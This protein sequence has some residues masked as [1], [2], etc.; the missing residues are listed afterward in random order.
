MYLDLL[1]ITN[2][3]VHYFLLLLTARLFYRQASAGR[4]LAGAALGASAVLLLP[5]SPPAGVAFA[6]ILAAPLLMVLAAFWPLGWADLL[7]CWGALFL[8][9]FMLA[10]AVS[11]LLNFESARR[12]FA[13][14]GGILL[15]LG[16][17]AALSRLLVL[18]RPFSEDKKWQKR[19]QV[20]LEVA[21]QGK[22]KMVPAFLDTGNRLRDP[23]CS[24]PVIV[25]DYRSLEGMLPPPVYRVLADERLEPW[26]ALGKLPDPALARHFTLIPCRGVGAENQLL[27]GL[28]PD[29]IILHEGGE[30]RSMESGLFLGLSRQGFG[31][32]AE[33]R[34]LLPPELLRAG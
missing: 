32:A 14:P 5:F 8:F 17:S 16:S 24:F 3:L 21:W 10:G 12:F 27:L 31:A 29:Y 1:F 20:Q 28:K 15:L 23:F 25:V 9:A 4:L 33:Y 2:M 22:K 18:L 7:L 30:S 13:A 34:A 6:V 19:W 26:S 11:A